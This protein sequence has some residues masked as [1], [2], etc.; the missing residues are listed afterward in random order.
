[1]CTFC[2]K[3][4]YLS[5]FLSQS[6]H[7]QLFTL[8][9]YR[10]VL[11]EG[12]KQGKFPKNC[13]KT[14]TRCTFSWK[15]C[16][17]VALPPNEFDKLMNFQSECSYTVRSNQHWLELETAYWSLHLIIT[18]VQSFNLYLWVAS[19]EIKNYL[20][21]LMFFDYTVRVRTNK[22]LHTN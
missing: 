19:W 5:L 15:F 18:Y 21:Y 13:K 10:Q 14:Q 20:L 17:Y 1:V 11:G 12:H 4:I 22:T 6:I 7:F 9:L 3:I 2:T 8:T 16:N